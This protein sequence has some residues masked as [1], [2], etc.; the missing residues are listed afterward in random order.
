M[1]QLEEKLHTTWVPEQVAER[2]RTEYQPK[3]IYIAGSMPVALHK[4]T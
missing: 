3:T 4:Q 2:F 1:G